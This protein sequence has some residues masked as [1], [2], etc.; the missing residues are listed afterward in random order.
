MHRKRPPLRF[1]HLQIPSWDL[2][3]F[4]G[5]PPSSCP[6]PCGG[7]LRPALEVP[8]ERRGLSVWSSLPGS[9]VTKHSGAAASLLSQLLLTVV[10]FTSSCQT[11][12]HSHTH[13]HTHTY[14]L[15]R[16]HSHILSHTHTHTIHMLAHL[17]SH[18]LT[19]THILS[20]IHMLTHYEHSQTFTHS[21]TLTDTHTHTDTHTLIHRHTH[22]L[23]HAHTHE[24]RAQNEVGNRLLLQALKAILREIGRA[25]V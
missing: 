8:K 11:H 3:F 24:T 25:H 5:P 2:G 15:T 1:S 6:Q 14:S 10:P 20:H 16:T 18:T 17:H 13:T 12:T 19:D 21:H 4:L 9:R 7:L 22:I 23:S